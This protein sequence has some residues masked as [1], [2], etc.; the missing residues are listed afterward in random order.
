MESYDG[1]DT[2]YLG[3]SA[4]GCAGWKSKELERLL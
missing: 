4:G 2:D 1:V 3:G